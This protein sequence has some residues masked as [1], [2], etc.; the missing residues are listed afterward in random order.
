MDEN[1]IGNPRFFWWMDVKLSATKRICD[2]IRLQLRSEISCRP[3]G[4]TWSEWASLNHA[5]SVREITKPD[6]STYTY[7]FMA[8]IKLHRGSA[9]YYSPHM[10]IIVRK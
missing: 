10:V 6:G 3:Q 4:Q 1:E 9:R 7:E 2:Q 5:W 8:D